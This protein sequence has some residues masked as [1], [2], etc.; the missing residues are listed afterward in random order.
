MNNEYNLYESN[1]I[2]NISNYMFKYI[3]LHVN[4]ILVV[5]KKL[6]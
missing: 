4:F 3:E 1:T 5:I 2:L 6:E